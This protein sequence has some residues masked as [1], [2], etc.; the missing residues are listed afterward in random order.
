MTFLFKQNYY[1]GKK[2]G[3]LSKI[4]VN[5]GIIVGSPQWA[6]VP[7]R[8]IGGPIFAQEIP[9]L[10][11]HLHTDHHNKLSATILCLTNAVS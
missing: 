10:S 4:C 3:S 8:A 6:P 5:W 11:N 2:Y 1:K 9:L 7:R